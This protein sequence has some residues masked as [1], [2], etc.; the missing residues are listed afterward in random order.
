M[1]I[2]ALV[3]IAAAAWLLTHR[4]GGPTARAL[5][6]GLGAF[7]AGVLLVGD[8]RPLMA[9]GRTPVYLL[10]KLTTGFPAE[11]GF[12]L[13]F[14]TMYSLPVLH[15]FWLLAGVGLWLIALRRYWEHAAAG[16]PACGRPERLPS[17]ATRRGA[18]RWG[19]I[20]TMIA[21]ACPLPYV[22]SRYLLAAG[23]PAGGFSRDELVRMNAENP[24]I[25]LF[26]AGL[27]TFGLIGSV[28][29]LGLVQRW[30]ECWPFWVPGLRGK[31]I[32]PLVAI[33]PAGLV[34]L[35]LPGAALMLVRID[36]VRYA[37]GEL[38]II[39]ILLTMPWVV[40]GFA[41]AA[42]TLAYW[43]RRR[44]E[45]PHCAAPDNLK[46]HQSVH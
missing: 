16:C 21:V 25:W 2:A 27:A 6:V 37:S 35:L 41:L 18:R 1:I 19:L 45:C 38:G 20:A 11:V 9:V 23:I 43:L 8:Y 34:S 14:A 12:E 36:L 17:W 7:C 29:T 22:F 4:S 3:G 24:G 30:G 44:P 33:V 10:T 46:D 28:L 39:P 42:A 15:Q 32:N 13:F 40:W 26:G 5:T 31:P